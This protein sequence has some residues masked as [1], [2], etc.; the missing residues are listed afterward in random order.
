MGVTDTEKKIG[1]PR[2]KKNMGRSSVVKGNRAIPRDWKKGS[3]D[4]A[5]KPGKPGV[6]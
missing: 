2:A 3:V 1:Q 6:R 5:K 4:A